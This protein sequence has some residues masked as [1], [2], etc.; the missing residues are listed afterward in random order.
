MLLGFADFK[1]QGIALATELDISCQQI[2]IHRFPDGESKV[3]LA[4]QSPSENHTLP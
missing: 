4:A 3:T 2:E 1:E